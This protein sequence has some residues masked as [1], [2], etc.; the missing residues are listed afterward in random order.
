MCAL[1]SF[2]LFS[3]VFF[4]YNEFVLMYKC[5]ICIAVY[6]MC[7]VYM[8]MYMFMLLC[9]FCEHAPLPFILAREQHCDLN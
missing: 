9:L 3:H 1:V 7:I 6:F 8:F 5:L 2:F 4:S